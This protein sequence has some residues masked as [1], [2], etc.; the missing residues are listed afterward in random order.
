MST[1]RFDKSVSIDGSTKQD[2]AIAGV[3]IEFPLGED[4]AYITGAT[5]EGRPVRIS[6]A[7]PANLRAAVE[8]L[9]TQSADVKYGVTSHVELPEKRAVEPGVNAPL[10]PD[11]LRRSPP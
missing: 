6:V 4:I 10:E 7:V 8:S 3:R 2:D 9:A 5:N 11:I 1:L